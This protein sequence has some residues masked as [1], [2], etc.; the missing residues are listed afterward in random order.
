MSDEFSSPK[1]QVFNPRFRRWEYEDGTPVNAPAVR[2]VQVN[3]V[4]VNRWRS[5]G[6]SF[7]E[8]TG[9]PLVE[10][11][12]DY[13][14]ELKTNNASLKEAIRREITERRADD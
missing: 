2:P 8:Y 4:F 13:L 9:V 5:H 11:P 3:E 12:T 1:R 14:R 7:G 6:L 10:V